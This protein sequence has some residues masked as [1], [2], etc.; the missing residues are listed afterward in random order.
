M[1]KRNLS[2]KEFFYDNSFDEYSKM[3][4]IPLVV[5]EGNGRIYPAETFQRHLDEYVQ[6]L[7]EFRQNLD[8]HQA[9]IQNLQ[10]NLDHIRN[11]IDSKNI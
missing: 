3:K 7:A 1:K 5:F 10:T 11:L 4:G 9:N 2:V 8:A 6:R